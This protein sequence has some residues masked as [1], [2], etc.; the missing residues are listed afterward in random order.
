MGEE[1][2]LREKKK[3]TNNKPEIQ[4]RYWRI[5]SFSSLHLQVT[6]FHIPLLLP[7]LLKVISWGMGRR[8]P[9]D[10]KDKQASF[11]TEKAVAVK[12]TAMIAVEEERHSHYPEEGE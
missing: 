6:L 4:K 9:K 11:L 1:E 2:N 3:K 10:R 12:S 7:W 8:G 5:M